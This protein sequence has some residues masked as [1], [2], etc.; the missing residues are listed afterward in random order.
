[1]MATDKTYEDG[2]RDGKLEAIEVSMG[3]HSDRLDEHSKRLSILERACWITLG[4]VATIQFIPAA[5]TALTAL[6]GGGQ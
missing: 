6:T 1:M 3:Q 2:L 4:I 5:Q